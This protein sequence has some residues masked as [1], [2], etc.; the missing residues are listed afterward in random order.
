MAYD[1]E[2]VDEPPRRL[3]AT[4]HVGPYAEIGAA[5]GRLADLRCEHGLSRVGGPL[6]GVYHDDPGRV[7]AVALRAHAGFVADE[8]PPAPPGLEEVRLAGGRYARVR[9]A[10]PYAG[11]PAAWAWLR[12]GGLAAAGLRP[13]PAPGLEIYHGDPEDNPPEA[14]LTDVLVP[15]A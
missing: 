11:L 6:V 4:L 13:S 14:L 3:L 10:G 2:I 7:P 15:L 12:A 9:V 5:F 8:A 1:L